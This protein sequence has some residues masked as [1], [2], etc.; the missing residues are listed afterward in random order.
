MRFGLRPDAATS[1]L[2]G[3]ITPILRWL[4]Y[5]DHRVARMRRSCTGSIT[6]IIWWLDYAD[7]GMAPIRRSVTAVHM[8]ERDELVLGNVR[9]LGCCLWTDYHMFPL[10]L[11]A[12]MEC[13]RTHM[14]DHRGI[15]KSNLGRFEPEDAIVEQREALSFLVKKISEPFTGKTVVITHHAPTA[16]SVHPHEQSD[17][18]VPAFASNLE[19]LVSEADVWVH[20]HIHLSTDYRLG[21]CRVICNPR[22][23]PGRNRSNPASAYENARF[24]PRKVIDV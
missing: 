2:R 3:S 22:G 17:P 15:R 16:R 11:D 6:S 12:S 24:D 14:L 20:G 21:H 10:H 5:A 4:L 13:A 8:L 18:L 23:Y 19:F 1:L 7:P 9:F